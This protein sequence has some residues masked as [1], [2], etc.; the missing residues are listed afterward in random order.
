MSRRKKKNNNYGGGISNMSSQNTKGTQTEVPSSATPSTSGAGVGRKRTITIWAIFLIVVAIM[1]CIFAICIATNQEEPTGEPS[2]EIGS[3][4]DGQSQKPD[5]QPAKNP[6][7]E[8]ETKTEEPKDENQETDEQKENQVE[9]PDAKEEEQEKKP[10][11]QTGKPS[12][13]QTTAQPEQNTQEQEK[14]EAINVTVYI[15]NKTSVYGE[16]LK[17]LT[18]SVKA[19]T[20]VSKADVVK[21]ISLSKMPGKDVGKYKITGKNTNPKYNVTFVD[22]TYTITKREMTV[23]IF[24]QSSYKGDELKKLEYKI[25]KGSLAKGDKAENVFRLTTNAN[26]D[27]VGTYYISVTTLSDNYRITYITA[28]YKVEVKPAD[29]GNNSGGGSTWNPGNSGNPDIPDNPDNPDNPDKPDNP[30]NPD[31][32]PVNPPPEVTHPT[33]P[34]DG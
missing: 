28:V 17:E 1:A 3:Q 32:P 10:T 34:P 23:S 26:K 2:Q 7:K 12:G 11:V 19:D 5:E 22:G 15:D 33:P 30:D 6:S 14:T 27:E 29:A 24:N 8:D 13:N 21:G 16:T 4:D 20:S 31:K 18:Y 9:V 25:S